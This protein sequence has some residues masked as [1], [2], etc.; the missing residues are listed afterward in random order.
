MPKVRCKKRGSII[1]GKYFHAVSNWDHNSIGVFQPVILKTITPWAVLSFGNHV[2]ISGCT[3]S[4][5]SSISIGNRVLVGSGCLITDSDS[6]PINPELRKRSFS[7]CKVKPI[8]IQ[9]DVFIGA[10]CIIL[11]G[12]TIGQGAMVGAGSVVSKDVPP[13][14]IVAGNPIKV[15][16]DTRESNE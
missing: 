16:G 12:V 3:I 8:V 2:G 4:A 5:S 1:L 9:D 10:R 13:Y 14:A 11:K 15:I 7:A 6:H